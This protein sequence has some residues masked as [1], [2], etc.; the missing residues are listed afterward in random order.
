MNG[1]QILVVA[2]NYD[3][4]RQV[5][6][7]LQGEGFLLQSAYTHFDAMYAVK[8]SRFDAVLIDAAMTDRSSGQPTLSAIFQHD[9]R[10][11]LVVFSTTG[12]TND[13]LDQKSDKVITSLDRQSLIQSLNL[14]NTLT[15]TGRIKLIDT[16]TFSPGEAELQTLLSLSKS[17]T[18]ILDLGE[19]LNRVV[20]AARRLTNADEGM[21]LLPDEDGGQLY[22]RARVGIDVE[23]ARNFR[24]K[25][26]DSLAGQ[27]FSSGH[28][29]FIGAK[30][31]QKVK[32]E[33]FA[34]ALLYV[35]IISQGKPIG[36]LG[37]NNR[38][39]EDSFNQ[40]QQ[41]LL[42]SLASYAAI[43]IENARAHEDS[44]QRARELEILVDAGQVINSS[45]SLDK[46]LPNI[47][48]Q[49][50]RMLNV[51]VAA[52]YEWHKDAQVLVLL[53]R[54]ERAIWKLKQ[55]P[56]LEFTSLRTVRAAIEQNRYCWLT[57][58]LAA[59]STAEANHLKSVGANAML[60]IPIHSQ[61]KL[62][63]VVQAFYNR[64]PSEAPTQENWSRA[65]LNALEAA[66]N[67]IDASNQGRV[68]NSLR[69]AE[70]INRL[71]NA[72]WSRLALRV[73]ETPT[74]R[75]Q[76]A[77]GNGVWLESP[78]VTIDLK[79]EPE[80]T[81]ALETQ[82]VM[83]AN[84]EE[85]NIS[86]EAQTLMS[87]TYSR[88]ILALPLILRGNVQGLVVFGDT[89]RSRVFGKREVDMG[90]AIVA[91]AATSLENARL[92]HDLELS[93]QELKDTQDRLI[94]TA[95]LSAMGELAAAVAHQVNNPL[96]TIVVD[97]ELM[98]S[99]EP[100]N[101][102][103]YKSL[104]AV[105]RAGKRAASVARRLLA[106]ARPHDPEA[107]VSS[108]DII[109][110]IKGVITLTKSHLERSHVK[111]I[112]NLPSEPMPPVYAVQGQVD[113][114]WLNLI[115]NAHDALSGRKDGCI[116]VNAAYTPGSSF[117]EVIIAD[118]GPGIP[119]HIMTEIFKPFFT[120]KPIGE[121]T[122]LGLHICRQVIERVNGSIEV[123]STPNKGTKFVVRLP[124]Q[125]E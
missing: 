1:K 38:K 65:R 115:L 74:M 40:Q 125:A 22:L 7:A 41:E 14:S 6:Q 123:E 116:T 27:V 4:V 73:E 23:A 91:Q 114:V 90:R 76:M 108:V 112:A 121:G 122:G 13:R 36:V 103:N 8:N 69:L 113:D 16:Q 37:V 81:T 124:V 5:Q 47:C 80:V 53:A 19:V 96:T 58:Q 49:L 32:T 82:L 117:I 25:T 52:I 57:T 44:L 45:I 64:I 86:P 10:P 119:E 56:P 89:E 63:G 68:Q 33:Y 18:E 46:A 50:V 54:H 55:G 94:Q 120:T 66:V 109:D 95:R 100:T 107:P 101:S 21:I 87:G 67:L 48:E 31:P 88:S 85:V 12:Y 78:Q 42:I 79:R 98:L 102:R 99:D 34:N 111:M 83:N 51:N 15:A 118:N 9:M 3:I 75:I 30:G 84:I 97:T 110:T 20:E 28:P 104:E 2:G 93:F 60:V 71:V 105:L 106:I 24:I 72:D 70:N 62:L 77:V 35:P 59:P 26:S 11:P 29:T 43:A 61:E 39:K 17:L 92:M